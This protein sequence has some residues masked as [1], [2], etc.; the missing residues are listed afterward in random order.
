MLCLVDPLRAWSLSFL[1]LTVQRYIFNLSVLP[2][3][4]SF[5]SVPCRRKSTLCLVLV[6]VLFPFHPKLQ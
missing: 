1:S 2:H 5:D 3:C 6:S 4:V